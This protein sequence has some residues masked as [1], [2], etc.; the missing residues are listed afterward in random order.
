MIR[1]KNTGLSRSK[2]VT[3]RV[4]NDAPVDK[5]ALLHAGGP[6]APNTAVHKGAITLHLKSLR[7]PAGD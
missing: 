6:A 3:I 4:V 7:L 5:E 2:R 1:Q